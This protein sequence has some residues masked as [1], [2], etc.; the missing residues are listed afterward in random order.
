MIEQDTVARVHSVR[1]TVIDGDPVS[2]QLGDTVRR[3]GIEGGGLRLGSLDD[4]SVEL[5]SR[6]LIETDVLLQAAG[7]DGVEQPQCAQTI[8]VGLQRKRSRLLMEA[9]M[10]DSVI[11]DVRCTRTFRMRP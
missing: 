2:V 5:G 9:V 3:S 8:D 6:G 10:R 1:L 4:L 7:S 11:G